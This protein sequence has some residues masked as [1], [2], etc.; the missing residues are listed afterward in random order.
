MD[1]ISL[2]WNLMI[3]NQ[4]YFNNLTRRT[5]NILHLKINVYLSGMRKRV[6]SKMTTQKQLNIYIWWRRDLYN[7][8][9][10]TKEKR[11]I[12]L[13]DT[14]NF[15][16]QKYRGR[17]LMYFKT[18]H[19]MTKKKQIILFFLKDKNKKSR[20]SLFSDIVNKTWLSFSAA[21]RGRPNFFE[22]TFN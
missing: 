18:C 4:S 16:K 9:L 10:P 12:E 14:N 2:N 8:T 19:N 7:I 6:I 13:C 3:L 1:V 17:C 20:Q 22:I 5:N 21:A 15:F 11:K